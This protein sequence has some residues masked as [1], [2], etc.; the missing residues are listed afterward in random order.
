MDKGKRTIP[1]APYPK[2]P[3]HPTPQE[4]EAMREWLEKYED[5]DNQLCDVPIRD[6]ISEI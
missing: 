2:D 6:K 3:K 5:K 4:W 1:P